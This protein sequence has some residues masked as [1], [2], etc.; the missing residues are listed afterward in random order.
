MVLHLLVLML[1][2]NT[3]QSDVGAVEVPYI[4]CHLTTLVVI[5]LNFV[6]EDGVCFIVF[7]D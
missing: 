4:A 1:V 6:R 5:D 3:R 2:I 7:V